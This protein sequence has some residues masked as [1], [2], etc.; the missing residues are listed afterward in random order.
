MTAVA[1]ARVLVA[2][3]DLQLCE[4]L[5]SLLQSAGHEA[6]AVADG[7]ACLECI[8]QFAPDVLV[9]D[10]A[11][12]RLDGYGVI[13]EMDALEVE[14]QLPDVI[15]LTGYGGVSDGARAIRAGAIGFLTKPARDVELL[16]LIDRAIAGRRALDQKRQ[17]LTD[18]CKRWECTVESRRRNIRHVVDQLAAEI[19]VTGLVPP[20]VIRRVLMAADEGVTNAVMHGGLEVGSLL[21][22]RRGA[23]ALEEACALREDDL[24]YGGRKVTVVLDIR[25]GETAVTIQDQG[26]GFDVADLPDPDDPEAPLR[27]SGRGIII[28]QSLLDEVRFEDGGRR[29]VLVQ[30]APLPGLGQAGEVRPQGKHTLR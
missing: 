9:L 22:E 20:R 21:A 16:T 19:E 18:C 6:R 29:V 15:V 23:R 7:A 28:M 25:P 1:A 24:Q 13:R 26:P 8:P 3:D 4:S 12:P 27:L 11:M 14:G 17:V 2:D 30:R 10:L 5:A